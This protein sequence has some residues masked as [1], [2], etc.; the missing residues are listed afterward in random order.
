MI[1]KKLENHILSYAVN[2]NQN[3]YS[4]KKL[5]QNSQFSKNEKGKIGF[6]VRSTKQDKLKKKHLDSE[7]KKIKEFLRKLNKKEELIDQL[8]KI[9]QM[10][11]EMIIMNGPESNPSISMKIIRDLEAISEAIGVL[12]AI[13]YNN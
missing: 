10:N 4:N 2:S 6:N 7:P 12:N 5:S 1:L 9:K 11:R 13:K 3:Q 8:G